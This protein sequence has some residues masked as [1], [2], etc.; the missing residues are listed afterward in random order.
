MR[1][2]VQRSGMF[3]ASFRRAWRDTF[4][5]LG[6]PPAFVA[7]VLVA[8]VGFVLHWATSG[9]NPMLDE[10]QVWL[11]YG[12]AASGLV[13][14]GLFIFNLL[15]APY[16]IERDNHAVTKASLAALAPN[17]FALPRL[18]AKKEVFTLEESACL[19]SGEALNYKKL[20]GPAN[21]FLFEIKQKILR[22]EIEAQGYSKDGLHWQKQMQEMTSFGGKSDKAVFNPSMSGAW[23]DKSTLKYLAAE[24]AVDIPGVTSEGP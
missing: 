1:R 9:L 11:I 2:L 7:L 3:K 22:G 20:S 13:F 12:L 16:R 19:L 5:V 10:I 6:G 14:S 24:Y 4:H 21:G 23:I 8:P 18:L 17:G 15:C